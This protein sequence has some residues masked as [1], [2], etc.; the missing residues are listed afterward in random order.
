MQLLAVI[1]IQENHQQEE[2]EVG[3]CFVKLCRM[4]GKHIYPFEYKCPR[5]IGRFADNFRIHQIGKADEAG[6]DRS[7]YGNHVQYVHIVHFHL[8]AVQP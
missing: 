5:H 4:P 1:L 3:D 2:N 7:C 6:A 8:A